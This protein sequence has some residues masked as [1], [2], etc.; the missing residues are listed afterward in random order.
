MLSRKIKKVL[1]TLSHIAL[2]LGLIFASVTTLASV[3][4]FLYLWGAQALPIG[5]AAWSAFVFGIK[6]ALY[7]TASIIIGA[8]GMSYFE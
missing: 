2:V 1:Y 7:C 5:V 3:G 8:L 4:Y 6:Y